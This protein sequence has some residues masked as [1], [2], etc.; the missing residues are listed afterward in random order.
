MNLIRKVNKNNRV[1]T[2]KYITLLFKNIDR[3]FPTTSYLN[4]IVKLED[5]FWFLRD[6]YNK[7]ADMP[8][9][10]ILCYEITIRHIKLRSFDK[11]PLKHYR[12][13]NCKKLH[14]Y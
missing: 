4:L 13:L 11:T 7:S 5:F 3:T 6:I 14:A 9:V 12:T 1:T 8:Q 10:N 2:N